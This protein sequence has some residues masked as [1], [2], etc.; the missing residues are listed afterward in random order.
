MRMGVS[1]TYLKE[2]I[3]NLCQRLCKFGLIKLLMNSL[4]L[5]TSQPTM[6]TL[7]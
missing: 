5:F 6:V 3:T 4:L 1:L 7:R 2:L